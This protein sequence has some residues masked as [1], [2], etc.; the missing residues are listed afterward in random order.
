MIC[1]LFLLLLLLMTGCSYALLVSVSEFLRL[2]MLMGLMY[3]IF[4]FSEISLYNVYSSIY[5]FGVFI[6]I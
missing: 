3:M 5:K 4:G 6:Y 1:V 2:I